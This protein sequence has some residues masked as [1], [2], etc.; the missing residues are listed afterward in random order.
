MTPEIMVTLTN[1]IAELVQTYNENYDQFQ[2]VT[3]NAVSYTHLVIGF[4]EVI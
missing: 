4:A 1:Q 3:Y 2:R